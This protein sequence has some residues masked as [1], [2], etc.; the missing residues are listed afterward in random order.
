[1]SKIQLTFQKISEIDDL[2]EDDPLLSMGVLIYNK[3]Y[4]DFDLID[5]L[6]E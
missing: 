3:I 6:T 1:M 5:H 2:N 4:L